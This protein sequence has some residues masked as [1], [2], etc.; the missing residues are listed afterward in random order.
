MNTDRFVRVAGLVLTPQQPGTAKG[1]RFITLEDETGIT[2]LIV[3]QDV[4]NRYRRMAANASSML[5]SGMLRKVGIVI[6]VLVSKL[7]DLSQV[8]AGLKTKSRDFR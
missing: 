7:E 5:G 2:N 8:L 4:R 3:R 1:I 6:H